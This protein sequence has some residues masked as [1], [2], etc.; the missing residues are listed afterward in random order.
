M[1]LNADDTKIAHLPPLQRSIGERLMADKGD[2]QEKGK[3]PE[4]ATG[5]QRRRAQ[6]PRRRRQAAAQER[7]LRRKPRPRPKKPRGPEPKRFPRVC[8]LS[9]RPRSCPSLMRELKIENKMRVPRLSKI[10]INMGLGE[11]RDNIKLLEA[12]HEEIDR[13]SRGK[14]R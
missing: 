2:K 1:E 8:A 6:G 11:A 12:A 3:R 13:R 5:R 9:T 7:P 4:K 14:S 10:V